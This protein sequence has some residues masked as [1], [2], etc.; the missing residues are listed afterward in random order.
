MNRKKIARNFHR[1]RREEEEEEEKL[2]STDFSIKRVEEIY[3]HSRAI[4][5]CRI[6]MAII[7]T[8]VSDLFFI[9]CAR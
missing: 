7:L 8:S 1:Y 6:S 2:F 9:S 4:F 5:L 3:F